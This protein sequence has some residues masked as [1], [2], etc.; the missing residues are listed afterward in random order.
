MID[1][2]KFNFVELIRFAHPLIFKDVEPLRAMRQS[3]WEYCLTPHDYDNCPL[4]VAVPSAIGGTIVSIT[5]SIITMVF[6]ASSVGQ[7]L[8]LA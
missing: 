8:K 2:P 4:M 3:G 1:A 5:F 7:M 6:V